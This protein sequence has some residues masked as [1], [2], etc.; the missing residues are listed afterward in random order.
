M[1]EELKKELTRS[2]QIIH[3]AKSA[4]KMLDKQYTKDGNIL[5]IDEILVVD[6]ENAQISVSARELFNAI[7]AWYHAIGLIELLLESIKKERDL[8]ENLANTKYKK[9]GKERFACGQV[10]QSLDKIIAEIEGEK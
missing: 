5:S 4:T 1:T 3:K 10:I 7:C 6:G 2:Q 8:W 9:N